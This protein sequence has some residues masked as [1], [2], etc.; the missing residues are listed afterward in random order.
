MLVCVLVQHISRQR[1]VVHAV[2][3]SACAAIEWGKQ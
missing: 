2:P 1:G 3:V